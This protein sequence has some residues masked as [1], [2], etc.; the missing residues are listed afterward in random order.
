M[1]YCILII[2]GMATFSVKQNDSISF[3][4]AQLRNERVA[5][6]YQDKYNEVKNLFINK[7]VDFPP[8]QVFFRVFK[9]EKEF[10]VWSFSA[11]NNKYVFIKKELITNTPNDQELGTIVR[12]M[13]NE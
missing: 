10:E 13:A 2:L 11:K 7:Q 8:S 4:S 6:A 3:E 12:K 5:I 1:L 9:L